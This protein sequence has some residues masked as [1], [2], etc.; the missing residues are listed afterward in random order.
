MYEVRTARGLE[1]LI[2]VLRFRIHYLRSI[3]HAGEL[4]AG[5]PVKRA[6]APG[7]PRKEE[8]MLMTAAAGTCVH[9]YMSSRV[10]ISRVHVCLNFS[11]RSK[12]SLSLSKCWASLTGC[13]RPQ[14]FCPHQ[15]ADHVEAGRLWRQR[16][17][18]GAPQPLYPSKRCW[19]VEAEGDERKILFALHST[20]FIRTAAGVFLHRHRALP[21][22]R[23][24]GVS[25]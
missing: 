4:K 18:S 22:R 21:C 6:T 23:T 25:S 7:D 13:Q 20:M 16:E 3:K 19:A 5:P 10:C 9:M 1:H 24:S 12:Q 14:A 2:Q 8:V 15:L 11:G 17:A